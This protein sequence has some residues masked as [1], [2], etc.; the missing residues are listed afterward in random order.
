MF[1]GVLTVV[2]SLASK[3]TLST[4]RL[5]IY[6]CQFVEPANYDFN[7]TRAIATYEDQPSDDGISVNNL[8]SDSVSA[9]EKKDSEAVVIVRPGKDSVEDTQDYRNVLQAVYKRAAWYSLVLALIV[10]IL[11]ELQLCPRCISAR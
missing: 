2:V 7:D 8:E 4:R 11:G 6:R 1:S 5:S 9:S 3:C 10:T